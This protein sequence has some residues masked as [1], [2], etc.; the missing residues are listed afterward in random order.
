VP[1]PTVDFV[2][3][4]AFE[5]RQM[6]AGTKRANTSIWIDDVE[7]AELRCD[8]LEDCGVIWLEEPFVSGALEAYSLLSRRRPNIRLAGGEG[9]HNYYMAKQMIDHAGIGF[10]QIDTGRIGGISDAKSVADYANSK[11]VTFVNHT[12]T[13]HLALSASLQPYA[14][15]EKDDL[16]ECPVAPKRLAAEL[17]KLP[18][19]AASLRPG[20][21]RNSIPHCL[22]IDSQPAPGFPDPSRILHIPAI[23]SGISLSK[24]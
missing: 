4:P 2:Q 13:T 21:V 22:L 6:L 9:C 3:S 1:T 8:A 19:H 5:R 16:C 23:S 17:T 20:R 11:G 7:K 18:A 14:G 10:I 24:R 15:L 12:F